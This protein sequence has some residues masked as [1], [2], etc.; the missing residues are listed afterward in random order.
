MNKYILISQVAKTG[1]PDISGAAVAMAVVSDG[2]LIEYEVNDP[3]AGSIVG[4]IYKGL[5]TNVF[6][7]T[8]SCFVNI[9]RERNAVLYAGDVSPAAGSPGERPIETLVRPGQPLVVQ[10]QRDAFGE[11]GAHVTTK[12]SLPGKYAVLLPGS[13]QC[14]VSRRITDPRENGRLRDIASGIL[15]EGCGL[16]MRTEAAGVPADSIAAD[17]AALKERLAD[18]RENESHAKIPGCIHSERDFYREIL[19][20]ALENDVARVITDDRVSYRELL[21][22]AGAHNPDI[23]YKI[24]H[25][26]EPWPLFAFHGVQ[27][28]IDNLRQRK[29]WL[30]CGAYVT[31]DHTEALTVVDVNTGKYNSAGDPRETILRVNSEAVV[32]T[33]RQLK[34]RDIGGIIVIDALRMNVT[35]DQRAVIAVLE[36]ELAKD[37]Q[38]T[39]IAGFTRIGLIEMTRKKAKAGILPPQDDQLI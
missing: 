36:S 20:R 18:M 9:G 38:K 19:F 8:Q 31:F 24:Q 35:A 33:A 23:S 11:K 2:E 3:G 6:S 1:S 7:G 32:E 12:I 37:R 28:D 34:L 15:P 30:K 21:S 10:V 17:V 29:L 25:Y 16:I 26:G 39:F 4:N 14:A 27:H 5:V 22:K 13:T